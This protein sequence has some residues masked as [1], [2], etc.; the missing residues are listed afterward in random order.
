MRYLGGNFT[1]FVIWLV[2]I[3]IVLSAIADCYIT[4]Q[5]WRHVLW[6]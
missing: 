2:L 5:L 6:N 4:F 1:V 3:L